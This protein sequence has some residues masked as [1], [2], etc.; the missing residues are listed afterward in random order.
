[1]KKKFLLLFTAVIIIISGFCMISVSAATY[2]DLTYSV[3]G[4][5]VTITDCDTSVTEVVIPE[6]IEDCPVTEIGSYAFRDCSSL[7]SVSIPESVTVIDI[8]AFYKC[9]SL[10]RVYITDI[11]TWCSINFKD[12]DSNPLYYAKDLY[13]NDRLVTNL[14]IPE[15]VTIIGDSAFYNCSSLVSVSIP[16]S[17]T[18]IGGSAFYN[19]SNLERVDI[20]DVAAWCNIEFIDYYSNPL[21]YAR[22]LY[23]NDSPATNIEITDEVTTIKDHAFRNCRSLIDVS[24]SDGVTTIGNGAFY[25]C[26]SMMSISIPDSITTIKDN[27]FSLCNKLSRVNITD[28]TAW[29]KIQFENYKSNP[30]Y[31]AENL[32]LND[33][34]VTNFEIPYGATMIDEYAFCFFGGITSISIPDSMTMISREAFYNCWNLKNVVLPRELLYIR[35][36]AFKGCTGIEN[37]FFKGSKEEWDSVLDYIGNENL[38]NAKIIYNASEKTYKFETNCGKT[39][40][41]ITACAVFD[42]PVV[43]NG[44]KTFCGWYDNEALSGESVSFPYYGNATTLYAGWTDRTGLSFDDA[45]IAVANREYSV[46]TT[47]SGQLIYYEFIP[48]ITGEYRFYSKGSID[49]FG[50]LYNSSKTQLISDDDDGDGNNFY[51]AYNLTAGQKYYIAA[52]CSSGSGTFTLV[53]ETD[54]VEGTKTVCVTSNSGEKIFITIPNYLPENARIILACYQDGRLVEIESAPNKNETIY[55]IANIGFNS[56]KVM[57]WESFDSLKP[58]CESENVEI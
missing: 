23:L 40:S 38:T 32:Y 7:V 31:D 3:S 12:Y 18:T 42:M 29:C 43:E 44:D 2:G 36:N 45:F 56:A 14:E 46:T 21:Y 20:T 33:R 15:G 16:E 24:I 27:A 10:K 51:I 9:S 41:D 4:G 34:L 58:I 8:G 49:T 57:V 53:T 25:G 5:K 6:F 30:L 13:L 37:V 52:K 54:C 11:A 28:I 22:E 26:V 48:K 50:Y 39:L 19:C 55:F 17:I 35:N 47:Q 1:M